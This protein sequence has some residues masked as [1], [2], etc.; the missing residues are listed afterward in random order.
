[1]TSVEREGGRAVSVEELAKN[2][3]GI[4]GERLDRT[5]PAKPVS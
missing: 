1:M 5:C 3:G 4:F 2:L